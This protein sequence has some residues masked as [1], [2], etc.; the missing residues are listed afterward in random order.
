MT[1]EEIIKRLEAIASAELVVDG[2]KV[3]AITKEAFEAI[4]ETAHLAI[5]ALERDRWISDPQKFPNTDARVVG[6]FGGGAFDQLRW[7][8][9]VTTLSDGRMVAESNERDVIN[10][11]LIAVFQLPEPPKEET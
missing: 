4:Q 1:N 5:S 8:D 7:F 11:H 2:L 10:E 3:G 6:Y 9:F